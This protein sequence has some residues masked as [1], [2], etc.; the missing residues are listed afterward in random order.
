MKEAV[1]GD[2]LEL[3][4]QVTDTFEELVFCKVFV[5]KDSEEAFRADV[6]FNIIRSSKR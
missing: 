1:P 4:V 3:E 2:V 5:R 6:V